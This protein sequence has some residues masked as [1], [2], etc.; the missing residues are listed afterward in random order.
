MLHTDSKFFCLNI[1]FVATI[2]FLSVLFQCRA[3]DTIQM[4]D[5][6][7]DAKL[8]ELKPLPKVHYFW[9]LSPQTKI[10]DRRLFELARITH[11]LCIPC[12]WVAVP[13]VE[14]YVYICAKVNK[15]NPSIKVTLGV[16]FVPWHQKFRK[17]LPPTD[18]GP[19]YYEEL[20]HF[21]QRAKLVRRWIEQS[22]KKYHS[23]VKVSAVLLDCERFAAKP[24]NKEW[25]EGMRQ[26]LDAIH[27]KAQS[28]FPDARIEWYGRGIVRAA[29]GDGWRKTP[30]WTG[31][32]IKA[33][34]SC[35]LYT[36]PEIEHTRE[37]FRRTCKLAD[38]MAINEVTPWVALAAG[39]RRNLEGV[40][41]EP[42][43]RYE[44][45]YSYLIGA[46]LNNKWYSERP[47]RYAPYDYAKVIVFYPGPFA[48]KTPDWARHFVAYAR[49]ATGVKK[50][51]DLEYKK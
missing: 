46:E 21:E 19:S 26:A 39:S 29:S 15:T 44:I 24:E 25:N 18:R 16:V 40:Y 9:P 22:N 23:D 51:E 20:D 27:I 36:V 17:D 32:E 12:E 41:F 48:P 31:E 30:Y 2:I 1:L 5:Y 4:S 8:W 3:A 37:I 33:P 11:T 28:F 34:L 14:K 13:Q 43:W 45:I 49:G 7:I 50:L 35:S 47:E 38:E 42:D 10:S 6:E